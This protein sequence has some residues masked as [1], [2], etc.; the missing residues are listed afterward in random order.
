M[1]IYDNITHPFQLFKYGFKPKMQMHV[2]KGLRSSLFYYIDINLYCAYEELQKILD[3]EIVVTNLMYKIYRFSR[4]YLTP[5]R[6]NAGLY[7]EK[8]L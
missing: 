8:M 5:S 1:N 4:Y 2:L 3:M 7:L 6:Y